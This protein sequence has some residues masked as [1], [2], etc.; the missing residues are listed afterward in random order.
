M[1]RGFNRSLHEIQAPK[2]PSR[3]NRARRSSTEDP[4]RGGPLGFA[5]RVPCS[6]LRSE[7]RPSLTNAR[8]LFPCC[9][10][11]RH[12]PEH[13]DVGS[14]ALQGPRQ[15]RLAVFLLVL[16]AHSQALAFETR[17]LHLLTH[18]RKRPPEAIALPKLS[19][20][21]A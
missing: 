19:T 18:R 17:Q 6:P 10:Y 4:A 3:A 15:E 21:V 7:R 2:T 12:H 14:T 20:S 5:R 13:T 16:K 1:L 9:M 11:A 8:C